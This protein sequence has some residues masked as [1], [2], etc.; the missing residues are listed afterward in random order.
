MNLS[1]APTVII[2]PVN[3]TPAV[4]EAVAGRRVMAAAA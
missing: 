2:P 1:S 4:M 3:M